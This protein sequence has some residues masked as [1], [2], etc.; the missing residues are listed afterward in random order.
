MLRHST[1]DFLIPFSYINI[2]IQT[3][4]LLTKGEGRQTLLAF[5]FSFFFANLLH[6]PLILD[7]LSEEMLLLTHSSIDTTELKHVA[8]TLCFSL[9][10]TVLKMFQRRDGEKYR[11]KYRGYQK[12]KITV[13]CQHYATDFLSQQTYMYCCKQQ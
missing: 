12:V 3:S 1:S 10:L 8:G 2:R 6:P 9:S 13:L 7:I 4:P 11:T 5:D